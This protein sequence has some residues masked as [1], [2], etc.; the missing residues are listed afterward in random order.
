[1]WLKFLNKIDPFF[2]NSFRINKIPQSNLQNFKAC[3]PALFEAVASLKRSICNLPVPCLLPLALSAQIHPLRWWYIIVSAGVSQGLASL[4][5]AR[6]GDSA[7]LDCSL[8]PSSK[9]ATTPNLFPLHVVEW[10]RLGYNVPVLIKFGVYAPRVHPNY[11]GKKSNTNSSL[12]NKRLASVAQET[13]I[14]PQITDLFG[15]K[16]FLH[17]LRTKEVIRRL[18]WY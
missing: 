4:V 8:T 14:P 3:D 16:T 1:M 17:L 10:V 12:K 15:N 6:E 11:K 7:E 5:H 2:L 18:H 9:E 13:M